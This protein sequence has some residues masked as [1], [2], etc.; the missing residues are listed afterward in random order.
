MVF[1][2]L[3]STFFIVVS[4]QRFRF[5]QIFL[6]IEV[7]QS[8]SGIVI[9]QCKYALDILIESGKLDCCP[10]DTPTDT[11][12]KLLPIQ[13]EPLKDRKRYRCLQADSFISLSPNS[14]SVI[15]QF[16]NAPSDSHWDAM[17]RILLYTKRNLWDKDYWQY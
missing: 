1:G 6:G 13:G 8:S 9:N 16:L 12:I 7:A 11:N 3:N 14:V 4:Y 15:S 5:S 10:W 17:T 2:T